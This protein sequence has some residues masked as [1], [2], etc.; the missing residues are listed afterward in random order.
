MK[1]VIIAVILAASNRAVAFILVIPETAHITFA[2]ADVVKS[3]RNIDWL[4][5]KLI[6]VRV[7]GVFI[8]LRFVLYSHL[9]LK[10]HRPFSSCQYITAFYSSNISS[11]RL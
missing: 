8:Y 2:F 1:L 9:R 10:S 7:F 4:F 6:F 3:V 11:I 5:G